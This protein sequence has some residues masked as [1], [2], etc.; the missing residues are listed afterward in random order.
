MIG[1]EPEAAVVPGSADERFVAAYDTRFA[2]VLSYALRRSATP[3]DAAD[4]TAE[5]FA[6]AWRKRS[7]LPDPAEALPWLLAVARRVI[8]N[9]RR[10][11]M[12]HAALSTRLGMELRSAAHQDDTLA[13]NA[14]EAVEVMLD[15]LTTAER[16]V[17]EL[18][19]WE[20]LTPRETAVVLSLPAAAVRARLAR[21]RKKLRI[22]S[23]EFPDG[24]F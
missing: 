5:T 15:S 14:K 11:H 7:S 18:A 21:A 23:Q 8:A 13:I 19:A 22:T 2:D 24:L 3:E 12:R 10:G 9:A 4:V 1:L 6:I 16:A 20:G 17:V